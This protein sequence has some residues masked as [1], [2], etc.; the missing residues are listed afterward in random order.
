LWEQITAWQLTKKRSNL[1]RNERLPVSH[2][3]TLNAGVKISIF[4][5]DLKSRKAEQDY[6][7]SINHCKP[8][9]IM[10]F[11]PYFMV[12]PDKGKLSSNLKKDSN[13]SRNQIDDFLLY[14]DNLFGVTFLY[15]EADDCYEYVFEIIFYI[16][17]HQY[18]NYAA[19]F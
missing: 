5:Y 6:K 14:L 18:E 1:N 11:D 9:R 17:V 8:E 10:D 3:F 2:R 7:F 4:D 12:T 13:L 15:K 19:A 16:V